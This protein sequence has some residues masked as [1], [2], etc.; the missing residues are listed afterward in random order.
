MG[1]VREILTLVSIAIA[2]L[3]YMQFSNDAP[4]LVFKE[5]EEQKT[6]ASTLMEARGT[7]RLPT[8]FFSHGGVS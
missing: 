1:F 4:K 3:A 5:A 7:A 6:V 8:Y 2:I